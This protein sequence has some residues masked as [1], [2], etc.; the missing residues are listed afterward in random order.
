MEN[1]LG[2]LNSDP[3]LMQGDIVIT[4]AQTRQ[5]FGWREGVSLLTAVATVVLVLDQVFIK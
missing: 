5:R 2:V 3:V 1:Q 4:E